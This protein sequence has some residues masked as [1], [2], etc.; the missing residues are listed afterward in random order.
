MTD[1][2]RPRPKEVRQIARHIWHVLPLVLMSLILFGALGTL[3]TKLQDR[4]ESNAKQARLS[5]LQSVLSEPFAGEIATD[6]FLLQG[7]NALGASKRIEVFPVMQDGQQSGVILTPVIARGYQGP[8]TLLLGIRRDGILWGVRALQHHETL[9]LGDG[10]EISRSNW[11]YQFTA[12]G[13]QQDDGE[14]TGTSDNKV[15]RIAEKQWALRAD[16]GHFDQL[17]GA[18]ITSRSVVQTVRNALQY[19]HTHHRQLYNRHDHTR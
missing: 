12:R 8:I 17:S 11:I 2:G 6:S 14:E 15:L 18:T 5:E 10:I 4:M 3:H 19:H 13:L 1:I 16:N 7:N 9:G